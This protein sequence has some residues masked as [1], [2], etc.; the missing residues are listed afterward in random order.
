MYTDVIFVLYINS[1]KRIKYSLVHEARRR[2]EFLYGSFMC[3]RL[4]FIR[5]DGK[6]VFYYFV[7]GQ[8]F[9]RRLVANQRRL[10]EK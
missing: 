4:S 2:Q 3:K 5:R 1:L 8:L 10:K 7:M 6:T 9:S